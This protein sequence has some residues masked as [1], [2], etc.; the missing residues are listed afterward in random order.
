MRVDTPREPLA[1][2][3][4]SILSEYFSKDVELLGQLLGRDLQ[5]WLAVDRV[6]GHQNKSS[7]SA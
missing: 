4:M 2:E 7:A 3:M 5:Q 6:P 1:P